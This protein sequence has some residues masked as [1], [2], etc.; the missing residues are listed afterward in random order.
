MIQYQLLFLLE[1]VEEMEEIII[2]KIFVH[3]EPLTLKCTLSVWQTKLLFIEL[4]CS[5]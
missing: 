3:F 1:N 4:I 2:L 5:Q